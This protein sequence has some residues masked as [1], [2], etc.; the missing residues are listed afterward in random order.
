[1]KIAFI[2]WFIG[3]VMLTILLLGETVIAQKGKSRHCRENIE[4]ASKTC[5]IK[6][7][8][9]E[10]VKRHKVAGSTC[11]Q[12]EGKIPICICYYNCPR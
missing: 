11:G 12:G 4:N 9:A 8:N 1:M 10:C 5:E 2:T 3:F 7:C 6:S